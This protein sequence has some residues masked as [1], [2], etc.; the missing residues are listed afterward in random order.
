M[1][2]P[3][4]ADRRDWRRRIERLDGLPLRPSTA[5]FVVGELTTDLQEESAAELAPS[6]R[7]RL[8]TDLDPAWVLAQARREGPVDPLETVADGPWWVVASREAA[9]ALAQLWRHAV[10]VSLAARRLAREANDPAPERVGQAGLLNHLGLWAVAAVDPEW[11]PLWLRV[12]D[13]RQR[14]RFEAETLGVRV[15]RLGRELAERWRL[16]PLFADAAW[17]SGDL[18]TDLGA[19]ARE[20]ARLA[21]LQRAQRFAAQTPWSLAG[22]DPVAPAS[23]DPRLKVLVAEV[24]S[25]CGGPFLDPDAGPREERLVREN[26]RL[27]RRLIELAEGQAARDRFLAAFAATDPTDC[28]ET[29][30]ETAGLAF[31]GVPGVT[32]AR[33]TWS[34][35]RDADGSAEPPC[36]DP[37]EVYP[38]TQ[39]TRTLARVRLRT[40]PGHLSP[41]PHLGTL[42]PAGRAWAAAVDSRARLGEQLDEVLEALRDRVADDEPRLRTAKLR[43]LA[44]FAAGAGHELNNPLA[45]IVGRAQLLLAKESDPQAVR[46]LRAILSQAQRAHRILRD[47]MYVARAPELRLRPCL[48]DEVWRASLR[49]ARPEADERAVRLVAEMPGAGKRVWADPDALRHLADTLLRNALEATPPGGTVRVES[50]GDAGELRWSVHDSGR[51]VT[52]A[53]GEHLFDPFYCGRQAGRGLG[54]GLPR[55]A[56][57]VAL[58]GGEIRWSS[59]PGQGSTFTVRLPLSEFPERPPAESSGRPGLPG[60]PA[61]PA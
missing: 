60:G 33:V 1:V 34:G 50:L 36:D 21:F 58:A 44:E 51:G 15:G 7:W 32:S 39:G 31:C 40:E 47:L 38:L 56:R 30:A 24:Q 37:S 49:D 45:V 13:R 23:H 19:S 28:P 55:A 17:L 12:A 11:L 29:W 26:A 9:D 18:G 22:P 4:P 16:E 27:R 52:E 54:L 61:A 25:R 43:A 48:P 53:E 5:R 6:S 8:V 42:L 14:L 57:F 20:P 35:D 2:H 59:I 41:S 46:S 10:A 3:R